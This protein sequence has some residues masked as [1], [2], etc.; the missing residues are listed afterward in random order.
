LTPSNGE[1]DEA[2]LI[3]A[4]QTD[5]RHFAE[6]CEQN[7]ELVYAYIVHA[8][9]SIGDSVLE[10]GEAHGQFQARP[11][12]LH[13]HVDNADTV[14]R[15]ALEARATS[16]FESRDEAYG[17]CVACVN[18]PHDNRWAVATHIRDAQP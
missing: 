5:P 2:P 9:V 12:L 18:D 3:E 10:M 6:L 15:A 8:K 14:Y 17:D 16:V 7:F 1:R 11:C 13:L 4:A